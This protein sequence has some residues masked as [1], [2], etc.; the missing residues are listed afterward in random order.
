MRV[1]LIEPYFTGSHRLWAE[2]YAAAS[3]HD[4]R[5]LTMTGQFWK[6]RM[7]GGAVELARQALSLAEQQGPPDVIL[8]SDMLNLPAFQSL[9]R[10]VLAEVPVVMYFH[11]NQLTYPLPPGQKRELAYGM[12]NWLSA[13]A[14]DEIWFNS[15]YHMNQ[16][17]AEVPRL[18]KHFPD[19]WHLELVDEVA[20]RARVMPV[21]CQLRQL[22]LYR[23][24]LQAEDG[25]PVILWNQRWEYDKC[26]EMFFD[27][28]R[29][30]E[31]RGVSF[32]VIVA[33]EN[34]RQSPHEFEE[35]RRWLGDRILHWGYAEDRATYARLLWQADI[36]VSTARHEFFGVAIVE[37]TYCGC[38]PLL[39]RGRSY[40][41]LIPRSWHH[42][43]LYV[44]FDQA[45]DMLV[46]MLRRKGEAPPLRDA[47]A[48]FDW[49]NLAPRYDACL[50]LVAEAGIQ[51]AIRLGGGS[52]DYE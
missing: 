44:G 7:L 52:R 40:P 13:L 11:E 1:W 39:P 27:L 32:R 17:F 25:P 2:G 22:D 19:Y 18:I 12:I 5:L 4:V 20:S 15:R 21:G 41:E 29:A 50:S 42:A 45:V 10:D 28:L 16:F 37:A 26:P 51:S 38:W 46:E 30:A 6:W 9:T 31:A 23:P 14:A 34:Y 47:M 43:V 49:A 33:G 48:A 8:A 3:A 35:A 36:V 24:E